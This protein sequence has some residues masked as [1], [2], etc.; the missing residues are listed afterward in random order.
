MGPTV[1]GHRSAMNQRRYPFVL[2]HDYLNQLSNNEVQHLPGLNSSGV[3]TSPDSAPGTCGEICVQAGGRTSARPCGLV[4]EG[5]IGCMS[6]CSKAR[7]ILPHHLTDR[8]PFI[9]V[10]LILPLLPQAVPRNTTALYIMS[11]SY[12]LIKHDTGGSEAS[13]RLARLRPGYTRRT[14]LSSSLFSL[15]FFETLRFIGLYFID[16]WYICLPFDS[17]PPD[18]TLLT[19]RAFTYLGHKNCHCLPTAANITG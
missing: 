2:S 16:P 15:F 14:Y 9:L 10:I 4:R 5:L 18:R 12:G 17:Q 8:S 1:V 6:P 11:F 13:T 7:A 3:L 19:P